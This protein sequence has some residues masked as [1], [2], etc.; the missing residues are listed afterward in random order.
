MCLH[1][2]LDV[3]GTGL[4]DGVVSHMCVCVFDRLFVWLVRCVCVVVSVCV[5]LFAC[6]RGRTV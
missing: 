3:C 4:C 5:R 2:L 1:L 6:L